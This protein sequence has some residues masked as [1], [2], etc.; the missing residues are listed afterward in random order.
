VLQQSGDGR[1][2]LVRRPCAELVEARADPPGE[3]GQH[4]AAAGPGGRDRKATASGRMAI[5][6]TSLF[7]VPVRGAVLLLDTKLVDV[8]GYGPLP[9][10]LPTLA[11]CSCIRARSSQRQRICHRARSSDLRPRC[12]QHRQS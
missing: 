8:R 12:K 2:V 6:A 5:P 10:Y 7:N 3:V 11:K 4:P 1:E 9:S